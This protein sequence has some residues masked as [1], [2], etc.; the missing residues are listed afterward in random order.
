MIG[1][2]D[3]LYTSVANRTPSFILVLSPLPRLHTV[4]DRYG[5]VK[6][7]H[8]V[9]PTLWLCTE[10]KQAELEPRKNVLYYSNMR[11]K[12]NKMVR[13]HANSMPHLALHSLLES[14]RTVKR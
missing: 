10:A 2:Y 9:K 4:N 7:F 13:F 12:P 14:V 5:V 3:W 1:C 6:Y 8:M 11:D